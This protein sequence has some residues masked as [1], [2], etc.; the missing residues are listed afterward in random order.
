MTAFLKD[1]DGSF[2]YA[3]A[4]FSLFLVFCIVGVSIELCRCIG[5][6]RILVS[7][8]FT[9]GGSGR[10]F[11]ERSKNPIGFWFVYCL[12]CLGILLL[13][14]LILTICFGWLQKPQS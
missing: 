11:V 14:T 3:A 13:I 9:Y 2:D 12:Y 1:A 7:Y 8:R 4:M 6:G 5:R 10:F